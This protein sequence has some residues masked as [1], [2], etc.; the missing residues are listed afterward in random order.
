MAKRPRVLDSWAVIEFFE[1]QPAADKVEAI[2]IE[3]HDSS[4]PLLI[5]VVNLGEVWYNIVR[6][7]SEAEAN[8]VIRELGQ[9][10]VEVVDADWELTKQAAMFKAKRN[11]SYADCCAAALAKLRKAEVVTGDKEFKQVEGDVKI[12]WL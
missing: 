8:R 10:G 5:S 2:L 4:T 6:G 11:I 7:H 12:L 9:L 1:N 3:A